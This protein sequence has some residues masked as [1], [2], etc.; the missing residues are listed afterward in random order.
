M[1][2]CYRIAHHYR[3]GWSA[4]QYRKLYGE[5]PPEGIDLDEV[6]MPNEKLAAWIEAGYQAWLKVAG[7]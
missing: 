5:W 2:N 3:E 1:L 6:H 4:H 7:G